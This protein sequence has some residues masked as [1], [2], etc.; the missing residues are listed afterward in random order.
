[1]RFDRKMGGR[2]RGGEGRSY[3]SGKLRR[4]R[5]ETINS[6]WISVPWSLLCESGVLELDNSKETMCTMVMDRCLKKKEDSVSKVQ[7]E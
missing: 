5:D 6:E 1:M 7:T 2:G 3:F 4:S